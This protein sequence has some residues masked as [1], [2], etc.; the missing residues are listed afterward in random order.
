MSAIYQAVMAVDAALVKHAFEEEVISLQDLVDAEDHDGL[1]AYDEVAAAID[2]TAWRAVR[3]DTVDGSIPRP[4]QWRTAWSEIQE[5]TY[6]RHREVGLALWRVQRLVR[7]Y[8]LH[9][10]EVHAAYSRARH[11]A[12]YH[13][14]RREV[15]VSRGY[16]PTFA[17]QLLHRRINSS[18]TAAAVYRPGAERQS[19]IRAY[20]G[21]RQVRLHRKEV[22]A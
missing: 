17:L 22:Q 13:W 8:G 20:R 16:E 9:G 21:A 1:Y 6:W 18:Y 3:F 19:I 14:R 5:F 4:E 11:R 7:R 15:G 2:L 12:A 10:S